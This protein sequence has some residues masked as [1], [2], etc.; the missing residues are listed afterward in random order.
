MKEILIENFNKI[1]IDAHKIILIVCAI[2]GISVDFI[3]ET[4]R[5]GN[6]VLS[7]QFLSYVLSEEYQ[8][9]IPDI[10]KL[11]YPNNNWAYRYRVIGYNI[12]KFAELLENHDEKATKLY[13]IIL[14]I[15]K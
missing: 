14:E 12:T 1:V 4:S 11:L 13:N 15:L 2:N 7:K 8:M 9:S 10:Y 5:S 3:Y 6:I